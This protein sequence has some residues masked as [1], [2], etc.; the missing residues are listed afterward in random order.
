MMPLAAD[1]HIDAALTNFSQEYA[2]QRADLIAA[3]VAPILPV[4]HQTDKY[5][6]YSDESYRL[7][8]ADRGPGGRYGVVDW[9]MSTDSYSCFGYGLSTVLPKEVQANADPSVD[10]GVVSA[11]VIM[12]QILLDYEVR[13][14]AKL[15][16]SSVFTQTAA[17]SAA[18]RWNADTSDPLGDV[19]TAK[20]YVRG[21]IGVEPNVA[22]MGYAVFS[23]LQQNAAVRKV[24]FGLNGPEQFPTEAQIAQALGLDRIVV[25]RATYR[26]AAN[27]FADVWGKDCFIAYYPAANDP[28]SIVPIRTFKWMVDGG[29]YATR[30]PIWDDDTKSWKYYVDDYSDEQVIS[31][32]SAYLFTTVVD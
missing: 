20:T 11:R 23:A 25:G 3:Q 32:Y 28:R 30:G 9:T 22:V 17:L 29:Q 14:A 5:W 19:A 13:V 12:D 16:S 31:L 6:V 26:T 1:L 27:T 10:P 4:A 21:K 7:S 2:S 24:V 15:F 8:V 18:D